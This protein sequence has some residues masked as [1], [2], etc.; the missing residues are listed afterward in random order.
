MDKLGT[1]ANNAIENQANKVDA[2]GSQTDMAEDNA[3][4]MVDKIGKWYLQ[5]SCQLFC[6]L[7][8]SKYGRFNNR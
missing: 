1:D 4:K 3:S 2:L 8:T 6:I 7:S 5:N